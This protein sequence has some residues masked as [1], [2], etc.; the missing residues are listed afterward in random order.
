[1]TAQVSSLI[2]NSLVEAAKYRY[3]ETRLEPLVLEK[4]KA[5]STNPY[6]EALCVEEA[7][8]ACVGIPG[9]VDF[10][11]HFGRC[12]ARAFKGYFEGSA[13]ASGSTYTAFDL[14]TWLKASISGY[15]DFEIKDSKNNN[16]VF[17]MVERKDMSNT[18]TPHNTEA[19]F[20]GLFT[21]AKSLIGD[22]I[23]LLSVRF[24]HSNR[25]NGIASQRFFGCEVKY[26]ADDN[27]I[28]LDKAIL[29][30]PVLLGNSS[31]G[32]KA[33][34]GEAVIP[35]VYA[36]GKSVQ[37]VH[38]TRTLRQLL[39]HDLALTNVTIERVARILNM[40]IRTL[41]RRLFE[42]KTSLTDLQNEIKMSN[43]I[44]VLLQSQE[45]VDRIGRY[46]GYS[47]RRSFVRAFKRWTGRTPSEYRRSQRLALSA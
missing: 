35:P 28:E 24:R 21:L 4:L 23:R 37:S 47:D 46:L 19:A 44:T 16:C 10:A 17:S 36:Q 45:S 12:M 6:I 40:S 7:L 8:S 11:L 18:L 34:T 33:L 20:A 22:D 1:M 25:G 26:L 13:V 14:F 38:V 41:Q 39:E 42:E 3:I 15:I 9:H 27:A 29:K 2:V 32:R 31:G 30:R 43:A 5:N